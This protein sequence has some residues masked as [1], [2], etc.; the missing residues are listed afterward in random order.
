MNNLI[1]YLQNIGSKRGWDLFLHATGVVLIC[2]IPE[3]LVWF[4]FHFTCP[5]PTEEDFFKTPLQALTV[6]VLLAPILE[7]QMMR[8]IF[9]ALNKFIQSNLA[10][11]LASA[12]IWGVLHVAS[13][14]WGIHAAWAFF[15]MGVCFLRL[16]EASK[17]KAIR[18]T[19]LIHAGCNLL[20]YGLYLLAN[21]ITAQAG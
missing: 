21:L 19:T 15:V 20:S 14:S 11:C 16:Q 10:L 9:F 12:L 5:G 18:L 13:E 4:A 8:M 1:T 7:T 6:A 17:Q 2:W 3:Q